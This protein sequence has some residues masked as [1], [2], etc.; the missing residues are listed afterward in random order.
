MNPTFTYAPSAVTKIQLTYEYFHDQRTTDR[1]I[2][3]NI[4]PLGLSRIFDGQ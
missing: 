2:F 1:V 4:D 3:D